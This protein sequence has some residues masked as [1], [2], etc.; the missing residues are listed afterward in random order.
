M[1]CAAG[2]GLIASGV[3]GRV[4]INMTRAH[5]RQHTYQGVAKAPRDMKSVVR[6]ESHGARITRR[7]HRETEYTPPVYVG[8]KI[9]VP[10]GG[11][12]DRITV[13]DGI[14]FG[15]MP[16]GIQWLGNTNIYP[17]SD[18]HWDIHTRERRGDTK[19]SIDSG[20]ASHFYFYGERFGDT[21]HAQALSD[22]PNVV[23]HAVTE[24]AWPT[25]VIVLGAVLVLVWL[26]THQ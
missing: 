24:H 11:S 9:S 23:I 21:F 14:G 20:T 26:M 12:I 16:P 5:L 8:D 22:N 25:I 15:P 6:V 4:R 17:S 3:A 2:V 7:S 18:F 10:I 1:L 19:Y 13:T